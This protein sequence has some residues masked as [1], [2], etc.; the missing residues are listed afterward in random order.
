MQ[1]LPP[2]TG[3]AYELYTADIKSWFTPPEGEIF[4]YFKVEGLPRGLTYNDFTGNLSGFSYDTGEFY[5]I[6]TAYTAKR[7]PLSNPA[8]Y[9][10]LTYKARTVFN[11]SPGK[12]IIKPNQ[13]LSTPLGL[14]SLIAIDFE[15]INSLPV[16]SLQV[17][18]GAL[19]AGLFLTESR[20]AG[21]PTSFGSSTFELK[22]TGP[23]G[24]SDPVEI[25]ISV[26]ADRPILFAR[27]Y[28]SRV[29]RAFSVGG[30][31]L[32]N[33]S[34]NRIAT[35][36]AVDV[37]PQGLTLNTSTGDITGTF[38]S[39]SSLLIS[40]LTATGPGGT[41]LP[42]NLE[43]N[44]SE[45]SP[46][47][48][49]GQ[50]F[51][52]KVGVPFSGKILLSD[53]ENRPATNWSVFNLPLGL[54]LDT[55]TGDV[56]GTPIRRGDFQPTFSAKGPGGTIGSTVVGFSVAAGVPIITESQNATGK[57]GEAFAHTFPLT[58][59]ANRPVT[60]WAATGLPAGLSLNTSTGAITG[61]PQNSGSAII[62]LTA[63]GP[64]GTDTKTAT[65]S[66]AVGPPVIV[67]GQSFTGAVG[68]AFA[69][70][71]ALDDALDR[72]ATAWSA[73]GLPAGLSL[74]TSA[75]VITGTP[76]AQGAFNVSLTA[77]GPGG[78]SA[79]VVVALIISK[80]STVISIGGLSH[81]YDGTI[82]AATV[83]GGA[84]VV[85]SGPS[86]VPVAVGTYAVRA[87]FPESSN[88]T[89]PEATATLIISAGQPTLKSGQVFSAVKNYQ[90]SHS[91][92]ALDL[93]NR[94][95]TTW[96]A[97][98]LPAGFTINSTTGII[99]GSASIEGT[100]T[101]T[102]TA[103]GP[104]GTDTKTASFRVS[105]SAPQVADQ[106]H[107]IKIG[108]SFEALPDV[109]NVDTAQIDSFTALHPLPAGLQLDGATGRIF[110]TPTQYRTS[111][112]NISIRARN[113]AGDILYHVTFHFV[114]G[115]PRPKNKSLVGAVDAAVNFF[116]EGTDTA[117]YLI[118]QWSLSS[119]LPEG[120]TLN[121]TT[122]AITGTPI[123]TV[124]QTLNATA[125]GPG[126]TATAQF[127]LDI[128]NPVAVR[129]SQESAGILDGRL[130]YHFRHR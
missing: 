16:T 33:P 85:Y 80:V 24:V 41:S 60:S 98:G 27:K 71:P 17:T 87:F 64:G 8:K 20:I 1:I 117:N 31:S 86:T 77:T 116:L 69:Q 72:P 15:D 102:L 88:F 110:G 63:T 118:N 14:N 125:T 70:T 52:A 30:A 119:P 121:S 93:A 21:T 94:P 82:K 130:Q 56:S 127:V 79:P 114:A 103:T 3:K 11:I 10:T 38:Q 105:V 51:N 96:A 57:T 9:E 76:S 67:A 120:L 91:V 40:R 97:T 113:A 29:G 61:I 92:V 66:I 90:S 22:A 84:S 46:V 53:E 7:I 128:G 122:G 19:P 106:S 37:L 59:S 13:S 68:V 18:S 81:I 75:G 2:S 48:A 58:D 55:T 73:T 12:P 39:M 32:I 115:T 44:I 5:I 36:W 43:W 25:S 35:S 78:V 111:S 107:N 50:N 83:S 42:V 45:G 101:I 47:V 65:I 28:S 74:N 108:E 23:G 124:A 89:A 100:T 54:I 62:S 34:P 4:L 112:T 26:T 99:S 6:I 123:A 129:G 109:S 104:G 126:G 49:P 95:V